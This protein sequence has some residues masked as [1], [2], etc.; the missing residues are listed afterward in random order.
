MTAAIIQLQK[1]QQA[2]FICSACGAD[3]GCQCNAP[4]VEKLAEKLKQDRDRSRR[5]YEKKKN[6]REQQPSHVREHRPAVT[7]KEQV[8][9][10]H[11]EAVG[12]VIDFDS[13]VRTWAKDRTLNAAAKRSLMEA[14]YVASD[15]L[16]KL[17]QALDGR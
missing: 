15:G 2:Q 7:D 11:T 8:K 6:Q 1:K 3:R 16:A 12:F 14:I 17:A 13:R 5:A 9:A 10:F 4:A